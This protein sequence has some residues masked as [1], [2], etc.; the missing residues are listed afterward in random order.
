MASLMGNILVADDDPYVQQILKDRL[1]SLGYRVS[2]AADGAA[3]L[4]IIDRDEPRMM[5]LDI[6]MP[7]LKG[8]QVLRETRRRQKDFP[9]VII[10]AFGTIDLAVEAMK[11][12]AFDFVPKPFKAAH[13]AHV[14][15]KAL[16]QQRLRLGMEL[17]T[18]EVDQRYKLVTGTSKALN[19]ALDI[20]RKAAVSKSTVLLLGESGVGKELFARAIHNWS[21]RKNRPFVPIN[22]AGLSRELLES[23]LFGYER[24]AFTGAQQTKK[25]K[26]ELADGGTVFLDEIGDISEVLQTKLLRFL[27]EREFER[28][29]GTT[30]IPVDVRIIA[31]TNR[32]LEAAVQKGKFREDL[33]YRIKVVPVS[34]PP[35]RERKEDIPE[36]VQYFIKRFARESKRDITGISDEA[37]AKLVSYEW[38]GNVRELGNIIERAVVIGEP[39]L[40]HEEDLPLE[41]L[42]R[43]TNQ[44]GNEN[45]SYQEAVDRHRREIIIK[46]LQQ[47][48]GNR[49]AAAKLLGLERSYFQKLIKAF[50]IE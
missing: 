49:S 11:E 44:A 17:L 21:D 6:E 3:A 10:T 23:E 9:V 29:G 8:L 48:Q 41:I 4:E 20:A 19:A 27:Q 38:P 50:N 31:A 33:Y 15:Q 39:P 37:L 34:L 43:S 16:E 14:V 24:G 22:C 46:A 12:G 47:T 7:G 28:V 1:E 13:I 40:I 5:F 42:A 45:L 26:I 30:L 36:L 32:D 25:G 18:E 35:L 2:L